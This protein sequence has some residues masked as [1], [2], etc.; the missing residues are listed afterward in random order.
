M[1]GDLLGFFSKRKYVAHISLEGLRSKIRYSKKSVPRPG[2]RD[3]LISE[4]VLQLIVAFQLV[5]DVAA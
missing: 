1:I 2:T 4:V 5:G 3:R